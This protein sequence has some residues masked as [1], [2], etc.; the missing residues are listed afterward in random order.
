MGVVFRGLR[1]QVRVFMPTVMQT[2]LHYYKC[3]QYREK[4]I[5][6]VTN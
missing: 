3:I 6:V 5:I 2:S 1:R 4:K